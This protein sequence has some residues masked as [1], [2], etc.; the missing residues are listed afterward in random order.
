[1]GAAIE[2]AGS[3]IH[4]F[5]HSLIH[6]FTHTQVKLGEFNTIKSQISAALR[7]AGGSLAVRDISTLVQQVEGEAGGGCMTVVL[8]FVLC[9]GRTRVNASQLSQLVAV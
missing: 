3:H 4:S 7:K 9:C 8:A 1:M 6:S 2:D 5:I